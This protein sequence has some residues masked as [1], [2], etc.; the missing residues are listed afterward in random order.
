MR[1]QLGQVKSIALKG[2]RTEHLAECDE[3]GTPLTT[4]L[5]KK[6]YEAASRSAKKPY[7]APS[8][9]PCKLCVNHHEM[10]KFG[11]L[12]GSRS[13]PEDLKMH[14]LSDWKARVCGQDCA[15]DSTDNI[16]DVTCHKC[17]AWFRE[18]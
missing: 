11:S 13:N 14:L 4:T 10:R 7:N 9:K 2:N 15:G 18:H 6:Q 3:S 12:R 5:C 8:P 17:R 16:E 1:K